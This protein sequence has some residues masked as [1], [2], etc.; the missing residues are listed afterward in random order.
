MACML[1]IHNL[2]VCVVY[3]RIFLR[4][5]V[6]EF[7]FF[8][9]NIFK[10]NRSINRRLFFLTFFHFFLKERKEVLPLNAGERGVVHM[11]HHTH[12]KDW[13]RQSDVPGDPR[14]AAHG[15]S[16]DNISVRVCWSLERRWQGNGVVSSV[17]TIVV[18]YQ[19]GE[20]FLGVMCRTHGRWLVGWGYNNCTVPGLR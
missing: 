6:W 18:V 8:F 3:K 11:F 16:Q 12:G 19:P 15:Q 13:Y 5:V 4:A 2:Y 14:R 17:K 7:E 10:V 9:K 1:N 20:C